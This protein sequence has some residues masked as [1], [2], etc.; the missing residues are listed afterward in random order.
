MSASGSP[1]AHA[2][3]SARVHHGRPAGAERVALAERRAVERDRE[4]ARAVDPQHGGVE[5]RAGA[6]CAS[7]RAG[8]TARTPTSSAR[9]SPGATRRAAR[10]GRRLL[11]LVARALVGE[12]RGR[13][14][15]DDLAVE[16]RAQ[17]AVVGDLADHGARQLPALARRLD[18]VEPLGRDDRDH[19]L[20]RLG[21]HDLPRLEVGLAQRH[22]V[23]VDVDAGAVRAPS[24]RATRRARRR[25]SPG[26]RARGRARRG[27]ATPR[28]A[29]C[30]GTGR[31]SAPTAASR[32]SPRDPG[33]RART[34]RRS[35]RGR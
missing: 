3:L 29:P 24:R 6:R 7:R 9:G 11:D 34:R 22:A 14:R 18:L 25:R 13:D 23:E 26:G 15:A 17:L 33:S 2:T 8:R 31:R 35:R 20:L 28:S 30:R 16:E 4:P 19:P 27:R 21:D 12:Q 1:P 10:L 5:A 32:R